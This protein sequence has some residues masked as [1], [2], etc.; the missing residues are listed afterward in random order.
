MQ[1]LLKKYLPHFLLL[2]L[3][4]VTV[5]VWLLIFST[6]TRLDTNSVLFESIYLII[7][8][9]CFYLI[10]FYHSPGKTQS[11]SQTSESVRHELDH[12]AHHDILTGFPNRILFTDR[13]QQ[14]IASAK[15]KDELLAIHFIGLDN[16]RDINDKQGHH[17]GDQV[18]KEAACRLQTCIRDTDTIAR[19][20]GDEF[21]VIQTNIKT[22]D[23][24]EIV[25]KKM[26]DSLSKKI[27][28]ARKEIQLTIST[29]IALYPLDTINFDEL[30][31]KADKSMYK[32]KDIS[33]SS[34]DVFNHSES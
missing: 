5:L 31:I 8:F 13:L 11:E 26:I 10:G 14:A 12:M 25:A 24:A 33:G 19:W 6:E 16:F 23:D 30:L 17:C 15:R 28:L 3:V 32:A 18:L 7:S 27:D 2:L 4:A 34:F 29:G 20:G 21:A 1:D 9:I 22:I